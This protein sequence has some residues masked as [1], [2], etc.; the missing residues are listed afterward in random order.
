MELRKPF[1]ISYCVFILIIFTLL[2]LIAAAYSG[3]TSL[4]YLIPRDAQES[5]P[6]GATC[7]PVRGSWTNS[8]ASSP[9]STHSATAP[10]PGSFTN[11]KTQSEGWANGY[12]FVGG[13]LPTLTAILLSTCWKCVFARLKEMEPIYQLNKST[14]MLVSPKDTIHLSY[15]SSA[16]PAVFFSS[17]SNRHWLT[18]F[19]SVNTVLALIC[20]AFAAETVYISTTGSACHVKIDPTESTNN[21]CKMHLSIRRALAWVLAGVLLAMFV[22]TLL[23]IFRLKRQSSGIAAE[24]SSIVGIASLHSTLSSKGLVDL[25]AMSS[26]VL[27][28]NNGNVGDLD[29]TPTAYDNLSAQQMPVKKSKRKRGPAAMHPTSLLL[30]W[31]FLIAVLVMILYYRF[32]SKSG[33]NNHFE[34]FMNSQS[35]GIKFFMTCIGLAITMNWG[36]IEKHLRSITPYVSM[37]SE[38]GGATADKSVLMRMPSHPVVGLTHSSSWRQPLL[39]LVTLSA[40]LSEMLVI[41]LNTVPFSVSTAYLAFELSVYISTAILAFMIITVPLL[42]VRQIRVRRTALAQAPENIAEV[43]E[44]LDEDL[45]G[46]FGDLRDLDGTRRDQTVRSWKYRYA[47]EGEGQHRDSDRKIV[48]YRCN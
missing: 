11:P 26:E 29:A 22:F 38:A 1:L 14:G 32:V 43:L 18:W 15:T 47:L 13:Y 7:A 41:T 10:L 3:A 2:Q 5:C 21:D 44:M 37:A 12:Y 33:T 8:Q 40:V 34:D 46:N 36:T 23:L 20:T 19:G 6:P 30:F 24:A 35:F 45:C 9:P 42:L 39:G 28:K 25:P 27:L 31:L 17:L 4:Q 16:W 48:A